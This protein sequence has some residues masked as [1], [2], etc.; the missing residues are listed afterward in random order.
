MLVCVIIY[1]LYHVANYAHSSDTAFG[2]SVAARIFIISGEILCL[3]SIVFSP[4][5]VAMKTRGE[6]ALRVSRWFWII[7]VFVQIRL[8]E[9]KMIESPGFS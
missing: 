3:I 8:A 1:A 2:K 5:D 6:T 9:K 4:V 7:I